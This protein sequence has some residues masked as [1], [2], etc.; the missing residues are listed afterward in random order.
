MVTLK[1]ALMEVP[2]FAGLGEATVD[3]LVQ[4]GDVVESEAHSKLFS[5][6]ETGDAL[7]V[8]LGGEIQIYHEEAERPIAVR[9][10]GTFIGE[11]A[12]FHGE[13]RTASAQ[14][15][16]PLQAFRLSKESFLAQLS[17][18]PTL[19]LELI[20]T[21]SSRAR[22]ALE[23]ELAAQLRQRNRQL[24][25]FNAELEAEVA[26][27]TQ[28]LREANEQLQELNRRD[29]LTNAYN[30]G[31]F[32]RTLEQWISR[33]PRLCLILIDVD[34][35]K[36]LNDTHGHQAGD[37]VLV[38]L[39]RLLE[40]QLGRGQFPARYRGRRVRHRVELNRP[41]PWIDPGRTVSPGG[42]RP[43]LSATGWAG[44]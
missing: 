23:R 19:A 29:P 44:R 17:Q 28:Q 9:G 16:T 6:G 31:Y 43:F 25:L 38:S 32:Q 8:I 14:A 30:R 11:I 39:T 18:N 35:F 10:A 15:L 26:R 41:H 2:L 36:H 42:G 22:T 12:L 20:E 21:V 34:H 3:Q 5:E 13:T 33:Q 40:A 1:S 37:R 7:Y 4:A 27:Q 24:E